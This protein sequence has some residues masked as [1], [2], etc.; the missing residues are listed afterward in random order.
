MAWYL[1]LLI[2]IVLTIIEA[3]T[4]GLICIWFVLSGIVTLILSLFISNFFIQFAVFVLLGM[5]LMILTRKTAKK[6]LKVEEVKT[7]LDRIIGTRGIVTEEITKSKTGEVKVDGKKWTAYADKKIPIDTDV[8]ILSI[9]GVK[10]KVEK[11]EE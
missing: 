4:S 3:S 7:N 11:W 6:W 2:V 9:D 10:L 1:W 5:L 8:K